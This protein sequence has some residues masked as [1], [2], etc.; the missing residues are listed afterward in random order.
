MSRTA[1]VGG[2]DDLVESAECVGH[3][4]DPGCETVAFGAQHAALCGGG[5]AVVHAWQ[6]CPDGTAAEVGRGSDRYSA[7]ASALNSGE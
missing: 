4:L 5:A 1:A 3:F 7:T 6:Q 2:G